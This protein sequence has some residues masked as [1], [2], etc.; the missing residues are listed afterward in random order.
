MTDRLKVVAS[1]DHSPAALKGLWRMEEGGDGIGGFGSRGVGRARAE[2]DVLTALH[3]WFVL[4]G[5]H[6]DVDHI[7]AGRHVTLLPLRHLLLGHDAVDLWREG[8]GKITRL[9]FH[10]VTSRSPEITSCS[11]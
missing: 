8:G 11:N 6:L 7:V 2:L 4:S 5:L 3:L 9:M 1:S 10:F